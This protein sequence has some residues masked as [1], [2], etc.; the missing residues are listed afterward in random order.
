MTINK[1]HLQSP[2]ENHTK[3]IIDGVLKETLHFLGPVEV[4]RYVD[5]ISIMS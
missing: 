4:L 2:G 1:L 3:G 5:D